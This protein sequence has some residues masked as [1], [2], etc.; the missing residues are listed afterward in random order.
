MTSSAGAVMRIGWVVDVQRDFMEPDGRLYVHD[1]GDTSDTGAT[2]IVATLGDAVAWMRENC[3]VIVYTGDWH[4]LEDAEIDPHAANPQDGTYPPHCMGRSDDPDERAG[5]E[6]IAVVRP[7]DP[8]VLPMGATGAEAA[9]TAREAIRR[10]RSVF[11]Q[12]NRFDV[13]EGNAATETFVATL[14]DEAEGQ[15]ELVVIGVARDV[16]VT[17]AVDGMQERGYRVTAVRDATW[18]LGLEDE[19]VTLGRWASRGSV[20][21]LSELTG[22]PRR[23][24]GPERPRVP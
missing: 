5:A 10:G 17:Q 12:K 13:F 23:P 24:R 1:L 4:A 19:E 14:A 3:T 15:M 2:S 7:I 21:T 6:L 16:C 20:V 8:L 9:A 11:I 22:Q 18:G